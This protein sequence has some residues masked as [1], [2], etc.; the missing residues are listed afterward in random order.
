MGLAR[1]SLSGAEGGDRFRAAFE[2]FIQSITRHG[3][4]LVLI[5]DDLQWADGATLALVGALLG[6]TEIGALLVIGAYRESDALAG[7]PELSAL[8]QVDCRATR[9]SLRPFSA[10]HVGELCQEV[11]SRDAAEVQ[12]LAEQAVGVC[13]GVEPPAC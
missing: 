8:E 7:P 5:L 10:A 9:I 3:Q 4:V 2:A 12:P 6:A 13:L 1:P 11:L